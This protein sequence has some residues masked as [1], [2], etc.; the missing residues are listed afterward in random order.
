MR[1]CKQCKTDIE[2]MNKNTIYCSSRCRSKWDYHNKPT[3]KK[4]QIDRIIKLRK[5]K[6]AKP[7]V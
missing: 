4:R 7:N 6:N 3:V 5:E 2:H 1:E